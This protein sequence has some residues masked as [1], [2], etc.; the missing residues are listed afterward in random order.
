MIGTSVVDGSLLGNGVSVCD[1]DVGIVTGFIA[2]PSSVFSVL[3]DV[4]S[5]PS[6]VTVSF[7]SGIPNVNSP[8]RDVPAGPAVGVGYDVVSSAE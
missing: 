7:E 5:A 6:I 8:G 3:L 1:D 2:V 4:S